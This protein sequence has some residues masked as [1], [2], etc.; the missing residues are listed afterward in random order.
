MVFKL[1]VEKTTTWISYKI[2][3]FFKV[4]LKA[5]GLG[6]LDGWTQEYVFLEILRVIMVQIIQRAWFEKI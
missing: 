1:Y 5:T 2:F 6:S 3:K 4:T